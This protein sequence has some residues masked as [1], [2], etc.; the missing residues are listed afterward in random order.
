MG[1]I[2]LR[3]DICNLEV[4]WHLSINQQGIIFNME[5]RSESES[6]QSLTVILNNY[7]ALKQ[8]AIVSEKKH[9]IWYV[10]LYNNTSWKC[11]FTRCEKGKHYCL[12]NSLSTVVLNSNRVV[13][14]SIS[15]ENH[16][17]EKGSGKTRLD[18]TLR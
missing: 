15:Y 6:S 3:R 14:K 8:K 4:K 1:Y 7:L 10:L 9:I 12:I 5:L 17:G 13:L 18:S 16:L 2:Q 11:L